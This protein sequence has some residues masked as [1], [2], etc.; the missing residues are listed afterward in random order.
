MILII[1]SGKISLKFQKFLLHQNLNFDE[2]SFENFSKLDLQTFEIE[3]YSSVFYLGYNHNSLF[4]NITIF[5]KFIKY[6]IKK[7]YKGKFIFFN[8]Q[9]I[10]NNNI[11]KK[12]STWY[13]NDFL[14]RYYLC[15]KLQSN[16][17]LNTEL[18]Y[19]NLYLPFVFNISSVQE[20]I[21]EEIGN[22]KI[23]SLPNSGKNYFYF[24]DSEVLIEI[25][26]RIHKNEL[27]DKNKNL[28]LYSDY[29]KLIDFLKKNKNFNIKKII[30][31]NY[32]NQYNL[33][34][35]SYLRFI[36]LNLIKNIIMLFNFRISKKTSYKNNKKIN[37][38]TDYLTL[39]P[40]INKI[41]WFDYFKL[42]KF[43]N[44]TFI[45]TNKDI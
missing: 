24:L 5:Y 39:P 20:N 27:F 34:N 8:T 41:L 16:I 23:V 6:L 43:K 2:Y 14:N 9:V 26:L 4:F 40:L 42:E 13:E 18:N 30:D 29:I 17:L 10:I 25:L 21:L 32:L 35:F 36:L 28:F 1:G 45:D 3:K 37:Q 19:F 11:S 44:I 7:N 33:S 15:K 22:T 38:R 12:K 31:N